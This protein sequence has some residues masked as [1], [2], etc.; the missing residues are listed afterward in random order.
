M[1][2][3]TIKKRHEQISSGNH[4][5]DLTIGR[6]MYRYC[7]IFGDGLVEINAKYKHMIKRVSVVGSGIS[8]MSA[9]WLLRDCAEVHRFEADSR[10]G[11]ILTHIS[12]FLHLLQ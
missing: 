4:N 2:L 9:T 6:L 8:R 11:G 12:N 5:N 10:F 3:S 7:I 1:F